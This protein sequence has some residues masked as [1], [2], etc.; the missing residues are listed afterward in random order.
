[1]QIKGPSRRLATINYLDTNPI[2]IDPNRTT[3]FVLL[4]SSDS[5]GIEMNYDN[6]TAY[7]ELKKVVSKTLPVEYFVLYTGENRIKSQ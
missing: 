4:Q 6:V 2:Y 5:A 7:V 3:D 1:M